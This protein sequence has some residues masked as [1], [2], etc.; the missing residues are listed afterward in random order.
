MFGKMIISK[1]GDLSSQIK[2]VFRVSQASGTFQ[3]DQAWKISAYL[4]FYS[5]ALRAVWFTSSLFI[6][7]KNHTFLTKLFKNILYITYIVTSITSLSESIRLVDVYTT[8]YRNLERAKK[9]PFRDGKPA[10]NKNIRNIIK[11]AVVALTLIFNICCMVLLVDRDPL[12]KLIDIIYINYAIIT[13]ILPLIQLNTILSLIKI[14]FIR[15]KQSL[16]TYLSERFSTLE[17][18]TVKDLI[19][20]HNFLCDICDQVN[21]AYEWQILSSLLTAYVNIVDNIY[22]VIQNDQKYVTDFISFML[23][24]ISIILIIFWVI[25]ESVAIKKEVSLSHHKFFI[26]H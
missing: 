25:E 5:V 6:T 10:R 11:Y 9:F 24:I 17:S 4:V 2:I 15:T 1:L 16:N 14:L 19:K 20:G 22:S 12:C 21:R 18:N 3:I 26:S 8:F 7:F 13:I 23:E